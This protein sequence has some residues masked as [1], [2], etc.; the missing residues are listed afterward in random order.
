MSFNLRNI[1]EIPGDSLAKFTNELSRRLSRFLTKGQLEQLEDREDIYIDG[2]D[3]ETVINLHDDLTGTTKFLF[4][5][6]YY[7]PTE[8][9]NSKLR[10][11]IRGT[12]LGNELRDYSLTDKTIQMYGDP[13][14]VDGA[15]HDDGIKTGGVKS[16]ALRLN[17]PATA[18]QEDIDEYIQVLSAG[19]STLD[20]VGL[21]VGK[22]Y[23]MRFKIYD[24][25]LDP[26]TNLERTLFAKIDGPTIQDAAQAFVTPTGRLVFIVRRS[27]VTYTWQTATSTIAVDTVYDCVFTF[28]QPTKTI[29]IYVNNIDKSLTAGPAAVWQSDTGNTDLWVGQRGK[30][31]DREGFFYGDLYDFRVYDELVISAAQVGYLYT[32]KW[33]IAN[34]PFGQVMISN[35]WATYPESASVGSFT[36]TSFTTTS[37]TT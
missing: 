14:L 9:D 29:H 27:G 30:G 25:S 7:P 16:I 33:T 26:E 11:W 15:P 3:F 13:V 22:S 12:N 20:V 37:F 5:K 6:P 21:A 24:L 17:R 10:L 23:F 32:N 36:T 19:T 1:R 2:Q 4:D 34:I 28:D 8:P 35:Y 31:D 18:L